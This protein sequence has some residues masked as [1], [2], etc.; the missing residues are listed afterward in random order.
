MDINNRRAILKKAS[1]NIVSFLSTGDRVSIIEFH[2]EASTRMKLSDNLQFA[3][4][5]LDLIISRP[6]IKLTNY[7]DAYEHLSAEIALHQSSFE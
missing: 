6:P 2:T 1:K 7:K 5:R 3:Q 4:D